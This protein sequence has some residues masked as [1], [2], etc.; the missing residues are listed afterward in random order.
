MSISLFSETGTFYLDN[1]KADYI[2]F[3]YKGD[4]DFIKRTENLLINYNG[5]KNGE[6][7]RIN[8][9]FYYAFVKLKWFKSALKSCLR[10]EI[11]QEKTPL[12]DYLVKHIKDADGDIIDVNIEWDDDKLE[13]LAARRVEEF[14]V[15]KIIYEDVLI[16]PENRMVGGDE[17]QM[18]HYNQED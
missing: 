15:T 12:I 4:E 11:I 7:H 8:D 9:N 6:T 14:L 5:L 16:Y 10:N 18:G 2:T 13:E 1:L 3:A 17:Y